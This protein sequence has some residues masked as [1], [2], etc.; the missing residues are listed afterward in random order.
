MKGR[1]RLT[2]PKLKLS[3]NDVEKAVVQLLRYRRLYPLRLQSGVLVSPERLCAECR[4]TV[5]RL[6]VGEPGIPD[7][8]VPRFF[9]E[10]KAPGKKLS[11][12]QQQKITELRDFWDLETAVVDDLDELLRW[13]AQHPQL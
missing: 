10:T 12:I 2:A 6:R 8:C 4:R 9:V 1:F 11:P 13:L 3:E 5:S 7:Y